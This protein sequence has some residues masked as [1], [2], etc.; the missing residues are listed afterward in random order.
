MILLWL[1]VY[2]FPDG[3]E[4]FFQNYGHFVNLTDDPLDASCFETKKE[5]EDYLKAVKK[6]A[7]KMLECQKLFVKKFDFDK[8][9]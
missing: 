5:A 2:R 6:S 8:R 7:P 9:H 1:L 4:M 3:K